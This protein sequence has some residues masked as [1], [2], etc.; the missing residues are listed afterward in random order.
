MTIMHYSHL[1]NELNKTRVPFI[2][3]INVVI[4]VFT[5]NTNITIGSHKLHTDT[6]RSKHVKGICKVLNS[7]IIL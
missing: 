2:F 5:G 6:M 7:V 4:H 3:L 1:T